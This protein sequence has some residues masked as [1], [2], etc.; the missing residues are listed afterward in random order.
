MHAKAPGKINLFVKVGAQLDDGYHDVDTSYQAVALY[1]EIC[2]SESDDPRVAA[3]DSVELSR[4]PTD[5]ANI[6]TKTARLP[7]V[8]TGYR[9]GASIEISKRDC[10]E[11]GVSGLTRRTW[12]VRLHHARVNWNEFH[13]YRQGQFCLL[14]CIAGNVSLTNDVLVGPA[15]QVYHG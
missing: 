5:G 10:P 6:T 1:E 13:S 4:V 2:L 14:N 3:S 12:V 9:G 11:F 7:A 15:G 8:R